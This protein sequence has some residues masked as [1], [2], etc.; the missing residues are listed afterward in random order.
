MYRRIDPGGG[1][2]RNGALTYGSASLL[3]W[4]DPWRDIAFVFASKVLSR[5][6][7]QCRRGSTVGSCKRQGEHFVCHQ[8]QVRPNMSLGGIASSHVIQG[9]VA[10]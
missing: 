4:S 2:R 10:T 1:G 3:P 8:T 5:A 9:A 7:A 6:C